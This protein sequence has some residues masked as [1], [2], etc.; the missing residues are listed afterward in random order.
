LVSVNK[1]DETAK[2]LFS[3]LVAANN[4][5]NT[6]RHYSFSE[7]EKDII[8][9]LYKYRSLRRLYVQASSHP[10]RSSFGASA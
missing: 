8:P 7:A 4:K 3:Q 5:A 2:V 6:A 9:I 10:S 1:N